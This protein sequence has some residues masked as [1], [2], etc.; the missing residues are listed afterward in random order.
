MTANNAERLY[1]GIVTTGHVYET[2]YGTQEE[3][4]AHVRKLNDTEG[5][6]FSEI[7]TGGMTEEEEWDWLIE[8]QG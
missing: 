1:W 7:I 3:A 4:L 8:K 5:N 6:G 2:F